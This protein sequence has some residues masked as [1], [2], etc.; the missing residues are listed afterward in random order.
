MMTKSSQIALLFI[1]WLLL[2]SDAY[3]APGHSPVPG[4]IA[5]IPITTEAD[6]I[7]VARFNG[8]RV[9][10]MKEDGQWVAVVG[11]P[12]KTTPGSNKIALQDGREISFEVE[13]KEYESQHITIKNKRQVNPLKQ[14][15]ERITRESKE[16]GAAFTEFDTQFS[17]VSRF[18]LP[19]DGPFSSPFGLRRFFNGQ[20]RNP[21]SGL[22]IASPAGADIIAAA[23][24]K[25]TATG[26]YFF[27]GNTVLIDH[28]HGLITMYCHMSKIDIAT[29]E[30][31]ETGQKIG[32]V[33]STGR[34]T[35]P[36]LH[37][38]VSLNNT[39]IDPTLF[40]ETEE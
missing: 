20:P 18:V 36:H 31:I 35:G 25:V 22:D 4:G 11:I 24:G 12:L 33:G 23:P 37:W 2:N 40:L 21:H 27:N 16:M 5:V 34:V 26:N 15:M 14:D 32:E 19:A 28:G 8:R 3:A 29:G 7:P 39:R 13:T 6:A 10:V 30:M 17:P 38:S 1:C 9:M